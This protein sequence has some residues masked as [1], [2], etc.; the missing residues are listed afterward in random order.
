MRV[1][2]LYREQ[3]VLAALPAVFAFFS[4]AG[5]LDRITAP[6]LRFSILG[7]S[8]PELKVGTL[9][10]YRLAWHGFPL[11]WTSR[12]EKWRPPTRLWTF[13]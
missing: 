2:T 5:N 12:V 3:W 9:I 13:R 1:R 7:Q 6:W 11:T 8:D 4:Q 10:Y